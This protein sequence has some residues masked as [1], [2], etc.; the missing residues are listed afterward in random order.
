MYCTFLTTHDTEKFKV[1]PFT[2]S[3]EKTL[4]QRKKN[5][6]RTRQSKEKT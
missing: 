1:Y 3:N 5:E 4:S 2:K 6:Q